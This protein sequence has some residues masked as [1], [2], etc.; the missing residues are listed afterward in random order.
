MVRGHFLCP[1]WQID[2]E[3][4][5]RSW[6]LMSLVYPVHVRAR[7]S[8]GLMPRKLAVTESRKL[9]QFLGTLPRKKSSVASA[10]YPQWH[11]MC[12]A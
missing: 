10:N 5:S 12:W 9:P 2:D 7:K 3:L 4:R 1:V 11:S 6:Y 8:F